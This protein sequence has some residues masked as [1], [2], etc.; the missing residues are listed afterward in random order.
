MNYLTIFFIQNLIIDLS[1]KKTA[2]L[3]NADYSFYIT[4]GTSIANQ[5]AI[6]A[7]YS[8]NKKILIDR[9]C[10]QSIHFFTKM[11]ECDID[12]ICPTLKINALETY[13]W[14]LDKLKDKILKEQSKGNEYDIIILTAQSYEG[15]GYNIPYVLNYLL[16]SGVKTRKFIIDE[17]WC[18]MNYFYE[19]NKKYTSLNIDSILDNFPNLELICTQSAHKS[20][21]CLRQSSIIHCKGLDGLKDKI[22]SAKYKLHTTSPNYSILTSLDVAQKYMNVY[23]SEIAKHSKF[24]VDEFCIRISKLKYFKVCK[25]KNRKLFRSSSYLFHDETKIILEIDKSIDILNVKEEL[26]LNNIYIKRHVGNKLILNFHIGINKKSLEHLIDTLLSLDLKYKTNINEISN[27]F[28]ISYPPG[29][30]ILF[31]GD[32]FTSRVDSLI[33]TCRKQGLMVISI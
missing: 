12:Y 28:V 7:L 4:A 23:G 5:I 1:Q 10:H 26:L 8:E 31:P 14:E 19:K 2:E 25:L 27:K 18:S 24:L 20:L 11:L 9:N 21:F 17:A 3:Y 15:I 13:V 16:E 29:V 22:E 6:L 32:R 30:P 33:R